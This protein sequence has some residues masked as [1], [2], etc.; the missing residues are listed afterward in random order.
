MIREIFVPLLDAAS[1]DSALDAALA[2]AGA[3]QAHV[4]AMV[5]LEYP[6]PLVTEFGYV[7]VQ[8]EQRQIE[9]SRADAKA[10]ADKARARLAR[11]AVA[12]EVRVTE[13]LALWSEETAALQALHCDLAVLG[14]PAPGEMEGS[15]RFS[16]TF[17][18]LL[19]R[20]GRPVLVVPQGVALAVPA[21]RAVLAWK[22]TAEASRALHE[23][24]PL[25]ASAAEIDVLMVDPQVTEGGHGEQPGAD[26]ARLLARHGVQANVVE[27]PREGQSTGACLLRHVRDT[28]AD[29]LVM[30]GYGHSHWRELL[31]G[32]ATRTVL[33]ASPTPVFFCH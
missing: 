4:T 9:Q 30:G 27:R 28:G 19:M 23:S 16:L 25:L 13:S 3:H 1:D 15:P 17:R 2:L 14:R 22:P 12:S 5:G 29:L 7:P 18:S 24:L 8:F 20:S 11:E 26:I 31:L 21:R 32:G 10:R 6:M 33:E